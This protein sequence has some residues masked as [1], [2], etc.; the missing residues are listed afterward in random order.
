MSR[1]KSLFNKTIVEVAAPAPAPTKPGTRPTTKPSTKPGERPAPRP[2]GVPRPG[3][4][5][6]PNARE[7]EE[8]QVKQFWAKRRK[9]LNT[10]NEKGI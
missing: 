4:Q 6:K 8:S 5:P 10:K 9:K 2:P 1:F 7:D 3:Y